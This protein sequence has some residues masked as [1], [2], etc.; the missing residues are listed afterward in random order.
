MIFNEENRDVQRDKVKRS[1][2]LSVDGVFIRYSS[3]GLLGRDNK[4]AL[5]CLFYEPL[6]AFTQ[7]HHQRHVSLS[8]RLV[9]SVTSFLW[10]WGGK[11]TWSW[12]RDGVEVWSPRG[13]QMYGLSCRL[14][15]W[16]Q[17]VGAPW[18]LHGRHS[19]AGE[20]SGV[21]LSEGECGRTRLPH[22]VWEVTLVFVSSRR[23]EW[24]PPIV[25][26]HFIWSK[27]WEDI[28]SFIT[29]IRVGPI[30]LQRQERVICRSLYCL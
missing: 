28:S 14:S 10:L 1:Q 22:T 29:E 2:L 25:T 8:L 18:P 16:W 5:N 12:S 23:I 15:L 9:V 11:K 3:H 13:L 21:L 17:L 20:L 24:G 6:C 4:R 30:R 27:I 19:R 7:R 26:S